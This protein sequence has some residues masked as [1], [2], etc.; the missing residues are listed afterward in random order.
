VYS[1]IATSSSTTT[2]SASRGERS[3]KKAGE[4]HQ[5]RISA[6]SQY[7]ISGELESMVQLRHPATAK[8][9]DSTTHKPP[10]IA[11][12]NTRSGVRS[13]AT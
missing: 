3:M 6:A 10:E 1:A 4:N 9:T 12:G 7:R 8:L 2:T 11:V 13:P 5:L